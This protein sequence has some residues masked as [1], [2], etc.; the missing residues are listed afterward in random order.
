MKH[1]EILLITNKSL[2][3]ASSWFLFY[4]LIKDARSFEHKVI[5]YNFK[6]EIK[7]AV[8]LRHNVQLKLVE[9][10]N[11]MEHSALVQ[12]FSRGN[13]TADT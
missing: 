1:V 4:L 6:I 12:A 9:D 8:S 13:P 7:A 2:F 11:S 10:W 5:N 3:V